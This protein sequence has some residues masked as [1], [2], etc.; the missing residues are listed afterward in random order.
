MGEGSGFRLSNSWGQVPLCPI[1]I[2][3][4]DRPQGA[5]SD[6]DSLRK[7][8]NAL[9]RSIEYDL[10]N[11][12]ILLR[13]QTSQYVSPLVTGKLELLLGLLR[14]RT[15]D[16]PEEK[17][18]FRLGSPNSKRFAELV[19]K[20]G[21]AIPANEVSFRGNLRL[22]VQKPQALSQVPDLLYSLNMF[23]TGQDAANAIQVLGT[24]NDDPE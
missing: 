24:D 7:I 5:R 21:Y 19:E 12:L 13:D 9:Q 11:R 17:G 6:L 4:L 3:E 18:L 20:I 16:V 14:T 2:Y 23:L 22:D 8:I 15:S 10:G 1:P